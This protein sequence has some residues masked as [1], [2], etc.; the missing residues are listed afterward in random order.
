M[1]IKITADSTIDLSP[2]LLEKYNIGIMPLYV[3][4]GDEEKQDGVSCSPEDIYNFVDEHKVLPKTAA[5]SEGDYMSLFEETLK[6]CD[7]IIHFS[8]SSEMSVSHINAVNAASNFN[9]V[10]IIDS[11]NL[12]TGTALLALYAH[13][14]IKEG[15]SLEEVVNLTKEKTDKVRASFILD[16]LNYLHKGGRCSAIALLGANLLKIKPSI[17]VTNGKMGVDKKHIGPFDNTVMKYVQEQLNAG[18][19]VETKRVF[20]THTKISPKIVDSVRKYLEELNIFEEILETT[21]GSTI[22]THCGSNTIG[23]LFMEK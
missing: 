19:N 12:S 3:H 17:K 22:T 7:A 18:S 11:R 20:I 8:I 2:E 23:V 14:L 9:N 21:A 4:F 5:A 15:K 6:E 1:R 10:V 16:K 13:D